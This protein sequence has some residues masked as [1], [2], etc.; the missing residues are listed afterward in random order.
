MAFTHTVSRTYKNDAG[1]IASTV[2]SYTGNNENDLSVSVPASSANQEYALACTLADIVAMVIYSDTALT[3]ATNSPA[4]LSAPSAPTLTQAGTGGT[5]GAETVYVKIT[6]VTA[7]G[8]TTGSS[9]ANTV[10]ASGTTNKVTVTSPSAQ[11][12]AIGWKPYAATTAGAETVQNGGAVI[13]I[14]TNYDITAVATGGASPPVSNTSGPSDTLSLVA[15][16]MIDWENDSLAAKPFAHNF[17]SLWV[18]N[19]ATTAAKLDIRILEQV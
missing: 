19:A 5:L 17:T 4:Q 7:A 18:S 12:G 11:T 2:A 15:K 13:A 16:A 9:E 3:I 8:E 14:G 6:L 1:T 10:I